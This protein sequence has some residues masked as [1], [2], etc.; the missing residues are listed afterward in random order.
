MLMVGARDRAR[1]APTAA[2]G[3]LRPAGRVMDANAVAG[4]SAFAAAATAC[5]RVALSAR[6]LGALWAERSRRC[7]PCGLSRSCST[8]GIDFAPRIDPAAAGARLVRVAQRVAGRIDRG[9][10]ARSAGA[11]RASRS[12]DAIATTARRWARS[13]APRWRCMLLA[14]ETISLHRV[15]AVMY[16]E[17]G[18]LVL[19]ASLSIAR[20]D[21][22]RLGAGGVDRSSAHR[23]QALGHARRAGSDG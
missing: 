7:T 13:P 15:D 14:V 10:A 6:S 19:L 16:A 5:L 2:L 3:E 21:R 18:P 9:R 8:C 23:L 4:L 20:R 22:H 1:A 17:A 11:H 12:G